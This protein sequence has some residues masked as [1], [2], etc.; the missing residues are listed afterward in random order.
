MD[1]SLEE[2]D[3]FLLYHMPNDEDDQANNILLE[4]YKSDTKKSKEEKM[5]NDKL[6]IK[7][8]RRFPETI[9]DAEEIFGDDIDDGLQRNKGEIEIVFGNNFDSN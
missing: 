6:E 3:K 5:F 8:K 1:Q 7:K 9:F 4:D 2:D